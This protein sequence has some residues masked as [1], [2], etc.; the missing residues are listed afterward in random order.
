M[1]DGVRGDQRDQ[2]AIQAIDSQ[3]NFVQRRTGSD[4]HNDSSGKKGWLKNKK[5]AGFSPRPLV[6]SVD[7]V[8]IPLPAPDKRQRAKHAGRDGGK[9]SGRRH[10]NKS[11]RHSCGTWCSASSANL[12]AADRWR[13]IMAGNIQPL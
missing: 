12:L 3:T 8:A 6:N 7:K 11:W 1:Q 4:L 10:R 5:A 2:S 9:S 13:I